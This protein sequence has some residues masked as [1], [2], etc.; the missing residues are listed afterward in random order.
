MSSNIIKIFLSFFLISSIYS[1]K[2]Q[3]IDE[4]YVLVQI[5]LPPKPYKLFVDPLGSF[6]YL[7]RP[8]E[9]ISTQPGEAAPI[10]FTNV[11][12]KFK[13]I[14]K[15]DFFYLTDDKL[16]NFRMDYVEITEKDSKFKCDGV[17][18]LGYSFSQ[19]YGNI[20]EVL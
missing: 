13:G 3:L 4:D 1:L 20:Y 12:G 7:F 18:G 8:V 15:N 10:E 17:L 11:L 2:L 5:G 14:W 19:S 16:M 9:S 6:T